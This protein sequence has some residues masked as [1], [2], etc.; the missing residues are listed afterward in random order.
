MQMQKKNK[1]Q[2]SMF[3][4]AKKKKPN[5]LIVD[6][7]TGSDDNSI[8]TIHP[9]KLDELRLFR[10]D[11]VLL[12]GKRKHT[13]VA[14]VLTDESCDVAKIRMNKVVRKNLRVRLGDIITLRLEGMD[15]PFG[16]RIH[17]L[18]FGDSVERIAGDGT[19]WYET[20]L[21]PYFVEAYRPIKKGDTFTI[22]KAMNTIEFK[23]VE[24]DPAP[25]CIVAQDTVIYAE[26]EPLKREEEEEEAGANDVGY[27]D[28]GG[29]SAQI[30]NIREAVE[31][32][33]R[34]PKLF[35]H[36][37][38][39]PPQ[40]VLLYGP[41]GS[42]KTL[43]ARAIANETG[44]FFFLINGPDIMSK[45]SGESESNL[46]KAFEE[47]EKNAPSIIF[48]DEIDCI[49]PKRD[50]VSGEMERRVVS[51][52]LTLMDGMHRC[53]S[54]RPVLVIAATNRP[55][56]IDL[57]LRR[58]G[59][60]D[61][62]ID[63]G[64]PDENGR[65]EILMIHSRN[66]KLDESVDLESIARET[67]G[68]V[69]ADLAELCT[70]AAMTCIREK[71]DLIDIES[72][73]ISAEI[74][75]SLCVTQDH[76]LMSLGRGHSPSSLRESRVEIPDVTWQDI[77]GLE[78]VKRGL[79]EMVRYPVEYSDK[80]DKFG[81]SPSKGVLLYGP[82]GCGK[83]LLAKAIANE[84]QVNFISVK[85]PELLNMWFGQSEAN[86][87][88]V[89]DKARQAAPCILFF[90]EL[91]SIAQ[92]RGGRAHDAGGAPDRI[93]NQLLTEMD[94]FADKKKNVFFI[95]ATNRPD[96]IDTALIRPGRLDQ[97]MYIPMPDYESRLAILKAALR[98]SPISSNVDLAF[99]ATKTHNFSGADL[100]EICQAAC[101]LAIRE[102]I[103]H[104]TITERDESNLDSEQE[105]FLP[106]LLPRHFEEAVRNARKSVSDRDL[107]QYQAFANSLHQ[108]RGA[109]TPAGQSLSN[110]TFP[111]LHRHDNS[112]QE[113][114]PM[115]GEGAMDDDEDL[116]S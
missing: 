40:G 112:S 78:D 17:V 68:F 100:T 1:P 90:D 4:L 16:K 103:A 96:I 34:H 29:C 79:Q 111:H 13:T 30:N 45:H 37:G 28:V 10:G 61:R 43:I 76:F 71:M 35:R 81:M 69:G 20:F 95:G 6:Q 102:D 14:V 53:S 91:D 101:K 77:G 8:I 42:G 11:V 18:P 89:F 31:L 12:Q 54:M 87:R 5:R 93:M 105:E 85:G 9:N 41:P 48:I 66:M 83:T 3:D 26:G 110:F 104:E 64:V 74:L 62:E 109:L 19:S 84:C 50:K 86:V 55:N 98:R 46:R 99:L 24:T 36:L 52:L 107:A 108:S 67:H 72:D 49:A 92:K 114:G 56:E 97:L 47:A 75:D 70:E 94:G 25:F 60:F 15:I 51:Q 7:P 65:L 38:V 80:F 63:L 33:L 115:A 59:R 88:N 23:V 113:R 27:D 2:I 39:R 58:F 32:P 106:E 22:H 57:S 44:A 21:K 73:S 116:Y 82:P